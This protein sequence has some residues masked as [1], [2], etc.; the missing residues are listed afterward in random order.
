MHV[1][2]SHTI[3]FAYELH[4]VKTLNKEIIVWKLKPDLWLFSLVGGAQSLHSRL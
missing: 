4:E 1:L 2:P 3:L